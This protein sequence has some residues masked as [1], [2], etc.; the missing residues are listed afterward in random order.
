MRGSTHLGLGTASLGSVALGGCILSDG[1]EIAVAT[2]RRAIDAGIQHIDTAP[3]YGEAERRVGLA[4]AD[5]Y[6]GRVHLTTKTGQD[7][8]GGPD[9]IATRIL[10]TFEH[11]LRTLKTDH[12]DQLLIHDAAD[13][14]VIF[15]PGAAL[16]TVERLKE[17][18][19]V[20]AI[21][22]GLRDLALHR[23]GIESGRIDAVLTYLAFNLLNQ[24]ASTELLPLAMDH[25]VRVINGSPLCMGLLVDDFDQRESGLEKM[26][27][28]G[29]R[30]RELRQWA[31]GQGYTLQALAL[32]YSLADRRIRVSL[33]G[34]RSL[35]ELEQSLACL[36]DPPTSDFWKCLENDLGVSVPRDETEGS[37]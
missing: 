22:F 5:G 4:L 19:A 26:D 27:P 16:D 30:R 14:D 9:A 13:A 3:A 35:S 10:R 29:L 2:I 8:S 33:T 7:F 37:V 24:T 20:G 17:E 21:G 23:A 11:S 1:D 25:D 32:R 6:R 28:G 12:V 18:G 31:H 36:V 34:S 15:K